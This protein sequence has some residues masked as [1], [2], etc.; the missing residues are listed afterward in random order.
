MNDNRL[1]NEMRR[2]IQ[3][4]VR[5]LVALHRARKL[6][7]RLVH[8]SEDDF[9][10]TAHENFKRKRLTEVLEELLPRDHAQELTVLDDQHARQFRTAVEFGC[11]AIPPSI[12][13]DAEI[14]RW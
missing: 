7:R 14:G 4:E 12:R 5:R 3:G 8:L 10:R 11:Y 9:D 13:R 2:P 1:I 6:E